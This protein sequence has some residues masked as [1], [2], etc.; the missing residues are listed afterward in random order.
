MPRSFEERDVAVDPRYGPRVVGHVLAQSVDRDAV[1]YELSGEGRVE[2]VDVAVDPQGAEKAERIERERYEPP[3]PSR[4][5]EA[6]KELF[7]RR[8]AGDREVT[9]A[10]RPQYRELVAARIMDPVSTWEFRGSAYRSAKSRACAAELCPIGRCEGGVPIRPG[11][12]GRSLAASRFAAALVASVVE[13]F[14]NSEATKQ[15]ATN[16]GQGQLRQQE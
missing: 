8:L 4:L 11:G 9:D 13:P 2:A 16:Q 14:G 3:D 15:A 1:R 6:A 7:R 10:N 12:R 5:S